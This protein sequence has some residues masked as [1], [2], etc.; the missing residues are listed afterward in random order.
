[1]DKEEK[2]EKVIALAKELGVSFND[3]VAY[4]QAQGKLVSGQVQMESVEQPQYK[5]PGKVVPG[6]FV[7]TDGLISQKLIEGRQIKAVVG[8]VDGSDVLAVCLRENGL[9]WSRVWL[10]VKATQTMTDGRDA[11]HEIVEISRKKCQEAQ[12]AKWCNNYA[13]DGVKQGEA[14]LPSIGELKKLF[15]NITAIN[16]SL[17]ELRKV[18]EAGA[19]CFNF[20]DNDWYWSSTEYGDCYAWL[21]RMTDGYSCGSSKRFANY[22]RP[23]I[24]IKL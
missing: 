10:E 23:V 17:K 8:Y 4:W 1:M 22:V 6:M 14:F 19:V 9:S 18:S 5:T 20:C 24:A 13:Q 11:T 21:L 12:A 7:Y 16:A 2:L 3:I 15:A